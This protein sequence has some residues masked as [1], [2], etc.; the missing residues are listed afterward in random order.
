M[1][2]VAGALALLAVAGMAWAEA[3]ADDVAR[4][5][6]TLTNGTQ[7]A[8]RLEAA[9]VLSARRDPRALAPL[10]AALAD[11]NRDV[12]WAAL[13][14]LGAL[15]DRRAVPALVEYLKR[16]EAYRWGKRLAAASLGA[17]GDPAAL[18]PLLGLL[19]D[20]DPFARRAA[21]LSLLRL[22]DRAAV[23]RVAE[24]VRDA[25]DE[26]LGTVRRE[27]RRAEENLRRNVA[28]AQA[29]RRPASAPP[30]LRPREWS[31]V[32]IGVTALA[33]V[34]QRF[35]EPLQANPELL[36]YPG[37]RFHTPLR[38]DSVA[39][40][41]D[42]QGVVESI[43]VFPGWGTVDRDVRALLGLGRTMTYGEFLAL[44]GRTRYGAGTRAGGKLHYLPSEAI[45]ESYPEMGMLVVYDSTD[46]AASNRLVKLLIIY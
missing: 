12:R 8:A 2:G 28:R 29:V 46:P 44:S 35:G 23:A 22:G 31:G 40:N 19:G 34:R 27:V 21:A 4:A 9:K 18:E 5:V 26:T 6:E 24:L 25:S 38:V 36:L 43:L 15:G 37:E 10:V 42:G 20:E 45:T 33:E 39:L 1:R 3:P 14:A 30:P 7:T 16:P 11:A 32:H 17:L 13:E 41:A